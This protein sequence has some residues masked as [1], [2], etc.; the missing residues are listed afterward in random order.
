MVSNEYCFEYTEPLTKSEEAARDIMV[1]LFNPVLKYMFLAANSN[2]FQ[3]YG[4]NSCRQTAILGA[5]VLR[6]LLTDYEINAFEGDFIEP[7]NGIPTPYVHAYITAC[8]KNRVLIIDLSRTE[9]KLLF[10][11][12]FRDSKC[13]G[14]LYPDYEDYKNVV[15][16][17]DSRI[18]VDEMINVTEGEYYTSII[19]LDLVTGIMKTMIDIKSWPK[20]KQIEY[21]NWIYETTTQ[22]RR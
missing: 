12:A 10:H 20:E 1:N 13:G 18:D 2:E 7:I 15:K 14:G 4:F 5:Y 16:V 8:K 21:R 19:P 3:K 11:P 17:N 6:T 22:L 9:K